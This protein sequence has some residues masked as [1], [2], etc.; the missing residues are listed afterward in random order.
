MQAP[1]PE[2]QAGFAAALMDARLMPPCSL[3]DRAGAGA[4]R[5]FSVYRNNAVVGLINALR[6]RFPV[7]CRLVGEDFFRAMARSYVA[8]HTPHSPLLM[9]YGGDFP[10]FIDRFTPADGV[11]YLPDV[12]RLEV[13]WSEAYHAPDAA[14]L[15]L[16]TLNSLQPE[17]LIEARWVLH[18]ST[19]LLRSPYPIADIW[20]AHQH[21]GPITGPSDWRPQEVLIVRPEIEVQVISLPSGLLAFISALMHGRL[22]EDAEEIARSDNPDFDAGE[23]IVTLFRLGVVV[24]LDRTGSQE[25]Q[26]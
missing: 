14:P 5:G 20:S 7:T 13:A 3:E 1:W 9:R 22:V 18:P 19:R 21:P 4:H 10:Q 24:A 11:P 16:R 23:S 8:K 6:E 25:M 15:D 12:A 26:T 17:S 2:T